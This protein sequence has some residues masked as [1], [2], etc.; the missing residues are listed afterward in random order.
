MR[1]LMAACLAAALLSAP[2]VTVISRQDRFDDDLPPMPKVPRKRTHPNYSKKGGG[3]TL[4]R[5]LHEACVSKPQSES[6][7]RMLRRR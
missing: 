3:S 1:G 2:G 7:K 4:Q 5:P 6:L